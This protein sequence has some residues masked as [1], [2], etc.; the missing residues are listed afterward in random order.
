MGELTQW[1]HTPIPLSPLNPTLHPPP[2]APRVMNS[3]PLLLN[4][5]PAQSAPHQG[6]LPG[7]RSGGEGGHHEAAG[8]GM[9][10][11]LPG[12]AALMYFCWSEGGEVPA[13]RSD[14]CDRFGHTH[15]SFDPLIFFGYHRPRHTSN[16]FGPSLDILPIC[17]HSSIRSWTDGCGRESWTILMPSSWCRRAR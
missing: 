2:I 14:I 15:V 4:H 9:R 3:T 8:G 13:Y 10:P 12:T 6:G 17:L 11:V 1:P 5:R 16:P 7:R